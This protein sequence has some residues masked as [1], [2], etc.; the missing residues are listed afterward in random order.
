MRPLLLLDFDGP[1]NPHTAVGVP[2]G[3][4]RHK[5]TEARRPGTQHGPELNALTDPFG[6]V[7]ATS[8]S[9]TR[10]G[11]PRGNAFRGGSS[12]LSTLVPD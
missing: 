8:R 12:G 9:T 2:P 3:Y 11:N 1:L 10:S 4:R 7:W 5:I 6:L